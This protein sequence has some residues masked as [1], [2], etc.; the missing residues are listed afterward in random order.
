M[1]VSDRI[2]EAINAYLDRDNTKYAIMLD[3]A[4]GVG[5]THF[6][7]NSL[8][9]SRSTDQFTYVSLY[10]LK[11]LDEIETQI[12]SSSLYVP[13]V[14]EKDSWQKIDK[15][16]VG[17]DYV[18][19]SP[20]EITTTHQIRE[21]RQSRVIC[22]DDLERWYGDIEVCL[23]YVNRLVEHQD[24]KC[25][26]IGNLDAMSEK[27]NHAFS[28]AREKTI[29]YIYR[30]DS[31]YH[32]IL[33]ISLD[34]VDY[35]NQ[36]SRKFLRSIVKN[37]YSSL[38]R[39][40]EQI[41]VRNIRIINEV[42]QLFEYIYRH[43]SKQF[44]RSP[45]LA[46]TYLMALFSV[47]ILA[48]RY[49][50]NKNDRD[51]LLRENHEANKGFKF[52]VDIGYFEDQANSKM[53]SQLR[54]LLDTTF[55][56]LD[57]I[58]LNGLCSI[59]R[60]GYYIKEDFAGDFDKWTNEQQYDLYLDKD[61]FYQLSDG[62]AK[63]VFDETLATMIESRS[64]T[65]PVTLL[66]LAERVISDI[67]C[68]VVDYNPVVFKKKFIA[69]V[70]DL[71]DSC[72]M[73]IEEI[74]IFDIDGDRFRN[75]RSLYEHILRRNHDYYLED[76]KAKV[77]NFWHHIFVNPRNM[78]HLLKKFN[79]QIVFSEPVEIE[80]IIKALESLSNAR[81]YQLVEWLDAEFEETPEDCKISIDLS[82]IKALHTAI[83]LKY[84][85]QMGV[86]ANHLRQI[87]EILKAR[88]GLQSHVET[89]QKLPAT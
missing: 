2:S 5:K 53:S 63:H 67:A 84:G 17:E 29:Q 36:V 52:L 40:L 30:Y 70:D 61:R 79:P 33:N 73:K 10:G 46:F 25:I 6:I 80:E 68:G 22:F 1:A 64:I 85:D 18:L 55:Y 34:L 32:T 89:E 72:Q 69:M 9:P 47:R 3:G 11:T 43:N 14:I 21:S 59:I 24:Q 71:Y 50:V 13:I 44:K 19:S 81:L 65:N 54:L 35:G 57:Q 15:K 37:N 45:N 31:N 8:I 12:R 20:Q 87:V 48:S 75:C 4:W 42:F 49:L 83:R 74:S 16:V 60:N 88:Q 28:N 7:V 78:K 26:L 56:R 62:E 39:L 86:R 27:A 41:S 58:S 23:S 38:E 77:T 51:K 76:Q 66:L 82:I